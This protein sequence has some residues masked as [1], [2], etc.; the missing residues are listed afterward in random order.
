MADQSA[1]LQKIIKEAIPEIEAPLLTEEQIEKL[2]SAG[3]AALVIVGIAGTIMLS[4]VAPN[5]IGAIDKIFF[6]KEKRKF[7][8]KE[9]LRKVARTF[10][11]LKDHGYIIMKPKGKDFKVFLTKLGKRRLAKLN[12]ANLLVPKLGPWDGKWWQVAADIPTEDYKWAADLF[13]QKLLEMKFYPLQRT[14]WFYPYDPR[15][16]I[17]FLLKHYGIGQFVTVMEISR[18]DY[19]DENAMKEFFQKEGII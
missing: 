18:L 17:E 11:Y 10:Y 16:E 7:S 5:V 12:F 6:K 3:A 13:R 4:A 19:S 9:K 8:T 2:K 14:L 15:K 1:N